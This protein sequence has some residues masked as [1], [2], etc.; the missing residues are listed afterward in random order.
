MSGNIGRNF[1]VRASISI[2][3]AEISVEWDKSQDTCH[4]VSVHWELEPD[5]IEYV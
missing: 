2:Q 1:I 4:I 5:P 3:I